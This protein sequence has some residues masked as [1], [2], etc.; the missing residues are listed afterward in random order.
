MS[1]TDDDRFGRGSIS[2]CLVVRHEETLIERCL[3]SLEGVVDEIV[4]VH[5]GEC[6]D[7]TL[8]IA[9]RYGCRIFV[10]PLIGHS[11][12]ATVFAYEQARCEWILVLDADE[13]LSA[14]L[15]RELRRLALD[16]RVNG[17]ELLWPRWDGRKYITEWGPYKQALFRRRCAHLVG[18]IHGIEEVDPPIQKVQLR[19]EHQ[20]EYNNVAL[21]TVLTKWRRWARINAREFL[22]PFAELPKFNWNGP[23]DWPPRRR[24]LNCLSPLLFLPYVPVVFM[25]NVWR[26]RVSYRPKENVRMALYQGLY[27][28][29]V[30]FYVA[31]YFY[32]GLDQ[33]PAAEPP[34]PGA[35]R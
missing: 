18:L 28:G 30:Q 22:L 6:E 20:P 34:R 29:M 4:L 3:T 8:E 35:V 9:E 10:R 26:E 15:R 13:F 21:S 14:D 7:R 27:A 32:L 17:Y 2:A 1:A 33:S 24:L 25:I 31:K 5:D 11:E 19:L 12:G 16:A 23:M